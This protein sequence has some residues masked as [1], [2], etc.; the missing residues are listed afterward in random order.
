MLDLCKDLGLLVNLDKSELTPSQ[1]FVF[2]GAR[3]NLV[4]ALVFPSEGNATKVAKLVW[5]FR[6]SK[7]QTARKWQSLIGTLGSRTGLSG[8]PGSTSDQSSGT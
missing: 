6:N 8:T 1:D 5:L 4:K 3:F 2:I 7:A